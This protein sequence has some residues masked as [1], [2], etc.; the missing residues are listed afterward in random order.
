MLQEKKGLMRAIKPRAAGVELAVRG[1]TNDGQNLLASIS[2]G[3]TTSYQGVGC[4]EP[5]RPA[6]FY[7]QGHFLAVETSGEGPVQGVKV[8][9]VLGSENLGTCCLPQASGS[10]LDVESR[11][12][13]AALTEAPLGLTRPGR[14]WARINFL[15]TCPNLP[16]YLPCQP[17]YFSG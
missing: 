5:K 13:N 17:T 16:A 8:G 4:Q 10:T 15:F 9:A 3:L 7:P 14:A 11:G 6:P 12:L 1:P 2:K